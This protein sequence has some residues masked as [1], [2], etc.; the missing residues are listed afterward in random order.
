MI[1]KEELSKK[2]EESLKQVKSEDLNAIQQSVFNHLKF[3]FE[4]YNNL[5]PDAQEVADNMMEIIQKHIGDVLEKL[6]DS[7]QKRLLRRYHA[8]SLGK[9]LLVEEM[10]KILESPPELK[11]ENSKQFRAIFICRLQNITDFLFDIYQNTVSGP[12]NFGQISLLGMCINELLVTFHLS[13]HYYTNQAYSHIRSVIENTD[14]IE[15]FRVK[16][17]WAEVWCSDDRDKIR[18]ELR[19]AEV[20]AKLGKSRYDPMYAFFSTLGPHS[21]FQ[22]V[23]ATTFKKANSSSK[24]RPQFRQW[25]GGCPAE[26]HIVLVNGGALYALHLVLL[27]LLK[28]FGNFIN[29]E[30]GIE[31]LKQSAVETVDYFKKNFLPWAKENHWDTKDLENILNSDSWRNL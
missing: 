18:K 16:P 3:M 26:H 30:E 21:T 6:P 19:P 12:A 7:K 27:Q 11:E 8:G 31:V 4:N 24:G 14:K 17:E 15:L 2:L 23:Q 9:R 5:T 20:R 13:Q 25:L 10:I 1:T 28:S 29:E 22:S